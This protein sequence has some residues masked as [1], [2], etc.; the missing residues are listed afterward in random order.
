MSDSISTT[1]ETEHELGIITVQLSNGVMVIRQ[2]GCGLLFV[3]VGSS[4]STSTSTTTSYLPSNSN[5]NSNTQ[6]H[7]LQSA[8]TSPP[9][10]PPPLQNQS[11][12]QAQ[13]QLQNMNGSGGGAAGEEYI[14][15]DSVMGSEAGSIRSIGGTRTRTGPGNGRGGGIMGIKKRADQVG[16]WLDEQLVGFGL[17]SGEGR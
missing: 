12:S 13:S 17:S 8:N 4:S 14:E 6:Q 11:Q 5:L 10:S 9:S 15:G 3:A 7:E 16:K 1:T 2:L